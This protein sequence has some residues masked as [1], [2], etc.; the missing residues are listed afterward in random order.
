MKGKIKLLILIGIIITA[1]PI[2][3]FPKNMK[4]IILFVLGISTILLTISIRHG[5]KILRLKLKRIEGQQ[6]TLIQ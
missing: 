1:L 3:G 5:I 4:T 2:L 6:G